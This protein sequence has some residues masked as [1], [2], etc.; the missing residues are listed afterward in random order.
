[1]IYKCGKYG[2]SVKQL[3]GFGKNPGLWI[4]DGNCAIKVASFGSAK[5]A[6]DFMSYL[7]Y[8]LFPESKEPKKFNLREEEN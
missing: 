8:L 7:D 6:Q 4:H 2:I 5:K 1:M 3:D